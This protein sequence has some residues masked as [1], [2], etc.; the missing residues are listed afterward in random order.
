MTAKISNAYSVAINSG[1]QKK[2]IILF[3]FFEN[4]IKFFDIVMGD[5]FLLTKR[6]TLSP[7]RI[8]KEISIALNEWV[9][10]PTEM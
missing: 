2:M 8:S 1:W 5:Y 7:Q 9:K 6:I 3:P 10:E 4:D